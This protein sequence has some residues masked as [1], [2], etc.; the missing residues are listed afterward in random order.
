MRNYDRDKE[1][2]REQKAMGL[3][4]HGSK[5]LGRGLG[6][7]AEGPASRGVKRGADHV[8]DAMENEFEMGAGVDDGEEAGDPAAG[9]IGSGAGPVHQESVNNG[10]KLKYE[11]QD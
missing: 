5:S 4:G 7:S 6:A 8:V 2:K 1:E 10:K 3:D 11:E 9:E